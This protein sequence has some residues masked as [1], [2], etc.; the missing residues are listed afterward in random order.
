[1]FS[2]DIQVKDISSAQAESSSG[3]TFPDLLSFKVKIR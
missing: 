2:V 1:M 3:G